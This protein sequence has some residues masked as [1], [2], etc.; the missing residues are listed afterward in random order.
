MYEYLCESKSNMKDVSE[1]LFNYTL[2]SGRYSRSLIRNLVWKLLY[3]KR[4]ICGFN[5]TTFDPFKSPSD[6][7]GSL[8]KT[9]YEK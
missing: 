3:N 7:K 1:I 5:K 8:T 2:E 6:F 4:D 9:W